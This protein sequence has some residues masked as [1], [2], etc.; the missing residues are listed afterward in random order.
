ML[1]Y[2]TSQFLL[3]HLLSIQRW[4]ND[5]DI[6]YRGGI[7]LRKLAHWLPQTLKH[8][9]FLAFV[10]LILLPFGA[11]SIYN[12]QQIESLMQEK[13]SMQSYEQLQ[14]TIRSLEDLMSIAFK[15]S[16]LLEQDKTVEQLL[17]TPEIRSRLEN[18][19]VMDDKFISINNSFFLYTPFVYYT[20]VDLH[21]NVY[22]SYLPKKK[23]NYEAV[24][25]EQWFRDMLQDSSSCKWVTN[26]ENYVSPDLSSS[27]YL[28]SLY[29]VFKDRNYEPYG[30]ARVSID[31][32]YWFQSVHR[33]SQ[34]DQEYYII[35]SEG[36]R[37]AQSTS[38]SLLSSEIVEKITNDKGRGYLLDRPSSS[39]V[40]YSYIDS[41]DWYI[42]SQI[43]LHV[44]FE[45]INSLKQRFFITFSILVL[46]FIFITFIIASAIT[47]PLHHLKNKMGDAVNKGLQ[48]KLP[49]EKYHGEMFQLA[50]TF[51]TMLD[52]MKH[53]IGKLKAEERQKEAAHFQMLL[54]QM[55]P[56]FLLNTLN[57]I[58]W[59]G[60]RNGN[61]EIEAICVS[62]GKLLETSLNS[63][64]DMIHLH[65]EIELVDAFVYIQKI[66]HKHKFEIVY[67]VD[68]SIQYALVPKL[69]IQPLVENAIQHGIAHKPDQGLIRIRITRLSHNGIS[70][71]VVVVEDNGIGFENS[72]QRRPA[73]KRQGIGLK[74]IQE[75]LS[76]L[77][78]GQ[79]ELMIDS[80]PSGTIVTMMIPFLLSTPY[81]YKREHL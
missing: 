14:R 17:K 68:E 73:R 48:I 78:K 31:Y 25:S 1:S 30:I 20:I 4:Y 37:V 16:I 27:T 76:L 81:D 58:K 72:K 29:C 57:T 42:V 74:N 71:L 3:S 60:I 6:G 5:I 66:R 40:N 24:T 18:K 13:I 8:R 15:T 19:Y 32:S 75:R 51:N 62:L 50:K 54:S 9:L 23:L 28:M 7:R 67:E 65:E 61:S 77:F 2:K 52:D 64:V 55:D 49:E 79:G 41:L 53:L 63:E 43:P 45:E 59:I 47:K 10:A 69:S 33:S 39:I 22:A 44:L 36:E 46:V 35:T 70:K 80:N 21:E 38:D 34:A 56:H 12:F 11:L 26:E